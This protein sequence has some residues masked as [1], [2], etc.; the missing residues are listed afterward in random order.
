MWK[1]TY[2]ITC[3][4]CKRKETVGTEFRDDRDYIEHCE[5]TKFMCDIYTPDGFGMND[6]HICVDCYPKYVQDLEKAR[7]IWKPY[8]L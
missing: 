2:T 5:T 3:N 6:F 8:S 4:R 1:K 7:A